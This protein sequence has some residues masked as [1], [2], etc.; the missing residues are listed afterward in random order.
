VRFGG[1]A[2]S[3]TF[4]FNA[5]KNRFLENIFQK[6]LFFRYKKLKQDLLFQK[7]A[8]KQA[9]CV[10]AERLQLNRQENALRED[11]LP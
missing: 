10:Y 8:P 1:L 6:P 3:L 2:S 7:L 11:Y 4:P 9:F 5:Q